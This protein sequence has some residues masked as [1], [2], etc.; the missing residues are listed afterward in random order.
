MRAWRAVEFGSELEAVQLQELPDPGEPIGSELLV[1]VAAAGIALPDLLLLSGAY[2]GMEHELPHPIGIEYSGTV[3]ACGPEVEQLAVGARV[4]GMVYPPQG[5]ASELVKVDE[6]AVARL[7]ERLSLLDGATIPSAYMTAHDALH[8]HG[9]VRAGERV[10]VLAAASGLGLALV[11]LASLAG[12]EVTGAASGAKLERVRAAGAVE[13]FDYSVD[14]WDQQL[15]DFDIVL[16]PI[17][18]SSFQRSYDILGPGGRLVCLDVISRYPKDSAGSEYRREPGDPRFDPV[19]LIADGKSVV[20][21]NMPLLWER[22][23]GQR[24]LLTEA[25]AHFEA[26]AIRPAAPEVFTFEH[27]VDALRYV[28]QRRSIG[29]VVLDLGVAGPASRGS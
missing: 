10:L 14:G 13:A 2:P 25:L 12:A 24:H 22:D 15:R 27:A 20:G 16:D 9:G 23:G 29:R 21:V 18:G 7:P 19:D 26:S 11:Q 4:C 3:L 1:E 5:G 17:G 28:Q 8:R 6:A